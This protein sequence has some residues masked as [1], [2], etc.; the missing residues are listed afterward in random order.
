VI[1]LPFGL[2]R[3]WYLNQLGEGAAYHVPL[4][5]RL[6]GSLDSAALRAA[7][8]DVV[9]RHEVLR[10]MFPSHDGEPYLKVFGPGSVLTAFRIIECT[11]A[12]LDVAITKAIRSPIDVTSE[13][14]LRS[15]LF[16]LSEEDHVLLVVMHNIVSDSWSVGPF[17]HDLFVAYEAR[18]A[19]RAPVFEPL[20]IGYVDYTVWRQEM[21]GSA[22]DPDSMLSVQLRHWERAL[23]GLPEELALPTDRPRPAE[24]S[25]RGDTVRFSV[26]QVVHG[27]LADLARSTGATLYMVLQAGLSVL[28]SRMG[29]GVDI[30]I[31]SVVAGRA[32]EAVDE[33]IGCFVNTLV[34]RA[35]LSGNPTFRDLVARVRESD[36]AAYANQDVPFERV[37]DAMSP[38]TTRSRH[39]L[40]QVMLLLRNNLS[41]RTLDTGAAKFDFTVSFTESYDADGEPNGLTGSVEYEISLFDRDTVVALANRLVAVLD[42]LGS[43]PEDPIGTVEVLDENE[44]RT[45]LIDWNGTAVSFSDDP[46]LHEL[47]EEQVERAPDATA[48]I[49]DD[50]EVSYVDL[51]ARANQL[52]RYLVRRGVERGDLVGIYLDRSPLLIAALLAVLKSG[53]SYILLDPKLSA[54]RLLKLLAETETSTVITI[55]GR[56]AR[57][58][59]A[60]VDVIRLDANL[61]GQIAHEAEDNLDIEAEPGGVACV[62]V[63]PGGVVGVASSHRA[64]VGTYL[65]QRHIHFG[66]NEV[67]LQCS[68]VSGAA[69]A[70]ELFGALLF[71]GMAVLQPGQYPEP[72][73]IARLVSKHEIT[74]VQ[75]P[76]SL[77]NTMVDEH[78]GMFA[79]IRQAIT[80]GEQASVHHVAKALCSFPGLRVVNAYGLAESG[81]LTIT[82]PVAE[83]DVTEASTVPIGRPVAGK[84][85]YVLDSELRPVPMGVPGELYL[86]GPCLADG[87]PHRP[88][89]TA[90]R[91]VANPF[92]GIGE[93]MYRTGDLARWRARGVLEHLGRANKQLSVRG[94]RVEPGILETALTSHPTVAQATVVARPGRLVAYVVAADGHDVSVGALREHVSCLLP[95]HVIPSAVVVLS[96]LPL[97]PTGKLDR[98]ALPEP[99]VVDRGAGRPP[100]TPLEKA[101]CELFCDILGVPEVGID[102]SFLDL[103]GH[104]VLATRL[105]SRIRSTFGADLNIRT[106]FESPTVARLVER[107]AGAAST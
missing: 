64:L 31:G 72:A 43:D 13:P 96:A 65:G 62:L 98:A 99:I 42:Q 91:F 32:D 67:F 51:N 27:R 90:E 21:L 58:A 9:D 48:L 60:D 47:F 79:F 4:A 75:L 26:D 107:L 74:A 81:G 28:L 102:D 38:V 55:V 46:C 36:L 89:R 57:L 54:A 59:A 8:G 78:P 1:P 49:F 18:S 88:A 2:R 84:G 24:P 37:V 25:R 93:R 34:L 35:D 14:P 20:P 106:V 52:A 69:F 45:L 22:Q 87:Y 53:A 92:G 10:T 86:A 16:G 23:A 33:L 29:A 105:I 15:W 82:F 85:V 68:P 95:E 11:E 103:G 40:F 63:P 5:V 30:P 6:R 41:P 73:L 7:V 17:M 3:L 80:G 71:G 100:R 70:L 77:F 94:Y 104:S 66:P 97:T 101:M 56:S 19:G 50:A 76:A 39:P 44:R 12:S 83:P 61:V